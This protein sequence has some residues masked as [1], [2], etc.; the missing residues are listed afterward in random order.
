MVTVSDKSKTPEK[1]RVKRKKLY[2]K[3]LGHNN[4]V[5]KYSTCKKKKKKNK[6]KKKTKRKR[7]K[8]EER[9][10]LLDIARNQRII[11]KR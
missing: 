3:E 5:A 1:R 6:K 9:R 11:W 10:Y 2:N 7:E 8:K 4:N